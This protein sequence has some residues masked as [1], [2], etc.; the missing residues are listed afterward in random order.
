VPILT[1]RH[2]NEFN[3]ERSAFADMC[4]T[5]K[6]YLISA[7]GNTLYCI[8]YYCLDGAEKTR[9]WRPQHLGNPWTFTLLAVLTLMDILYWVF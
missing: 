1:N 3:Y 5:P 4:F 9:N 2:F 7:N 8:R 6:T